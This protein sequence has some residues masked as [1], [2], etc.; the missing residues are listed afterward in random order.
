MAQGTV[1]ATKKEPVSLA[2][3]ARAVK[4]EKPATPAKVVYTN[5]NIAAGRTKLAFPDVEVERGDNSAE[6]LQAMSVYRNLHTNGE[7]DNAMKEWFDQ[8]DGYLQSFFEQRERLVADRN[9]GY[10]NNYPQPT[11]EAGYREY[12]AEMKRRQS[13]A[14]N[15]GEQIQKLGRMI[16]KL[17]QGLM[18][19]QS[20]LQTERIKYD[21]FKIRY[22]STDS[23]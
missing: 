14:Q 23:Y 15:A 9:G 4:K 1:P 16:S 6:I 22:N 8:Q 17:Q 5:D 10:M 19:V 21:W 2:D 18:K 13:S 12:M 7:T 3:A 11:T 20:G